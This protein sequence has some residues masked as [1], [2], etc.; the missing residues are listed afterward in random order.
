M[1]I[2]YLHWKKKEEL[3]NDS[4]M[5]IKSPSPSDKQI[6]CGMAIKWLKKNTDKE[7]KGLD[8]APKKRLEDIAEDRSEAYERI[9]REMD[10]R[11]RWREEHPEEYAKRL[12]D[13]VKKYEGLDEAAI[14]WC[15]ENNKGLALGGDRRTHYLCDG[16]EVFKAGAEWMAEQGVTVEKT[17]GE[18]EGVCAGHPVF[19]NGFEIDELDVP[20]LNSKEINYGDKVIVQI[21]KKT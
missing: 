1:T 8:G 14:E 17:V 21:R 10:E 16:E 3:I 4:K 6:A 13:A 11:Q 15:K 18:I 12:D 5:A 20:F 2:E 19:K 7:P 9:N